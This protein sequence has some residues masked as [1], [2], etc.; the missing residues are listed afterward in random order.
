MRFQVYSLVNNNNNNKKTGINY[1]DELSPQERTQVFKQAKEHWNS[2][3]A[4]QRTEHLAEYYKTIREKK[5]ADGGRLMNVPDIDVVRE[6]L[7]VDMPKQKQAAIEEAERNGRPD[8][9]EDLRRK[10]LGVD[11]LEIKLYDQDTGKEIV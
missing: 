4:E 11:V 1:L 6:I 10:R 2:L 7:N 3:T 9:A 5:R 8:I